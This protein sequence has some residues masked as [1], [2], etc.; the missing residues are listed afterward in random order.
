MVE[1]PNRTPHHQAGDPGM[2]SAPAAPE[3]V[4]RRRRARFGALR[5]RFERRSSR[6]GNLNLLLFVAV[7]ASLGLAFWR[8]NVIFYG[9]AGVVA[10]GLIVSLVYHDRTKRLLSRYTG[11]YRLNDEACAGLRVTGKAS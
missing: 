7:L 6:N 10:L 1:N 8:E 5:D 9:A 11:L 4:Y 2:A 3:A